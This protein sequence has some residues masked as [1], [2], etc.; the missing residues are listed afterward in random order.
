LE[1]D[2]STASSLAR[3]RQIGSVIVALCGQTERRNAFGKTRAARASSF[4]HMY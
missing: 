2:Q 4:I 3:K 1:G